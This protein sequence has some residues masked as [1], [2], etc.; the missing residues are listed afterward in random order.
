MKSFTDYMLIIWLTGSLCSRHKVTENY[1]KTKKPEIR[2][3][4]ADFILCNPIYL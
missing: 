4:P 2:G 1:F 3:S